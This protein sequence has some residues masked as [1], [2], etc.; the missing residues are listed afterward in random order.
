M[1]PIFMSVSS[2]N[3]IMLLND[4]QYA[5]D[6]PDQ[7]VQASGQHHQSQVR[8]SLERSYCVLMLRKAYGSQFAR[9]EFASISPPAWLRMTFLSYTAS[10]ESDIRLWFWNGF[11]RSMQDARSYELESAVLY[12]FQQIVVP[13]SLLYKA[14][15]QSE[16]Q[17]FLSG[18]TPLNSIETFTTHKGVAIS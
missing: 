10:D 18:E 12:T 14:V 16:Y 6:Q 1:L 17:H 2:L 9:F 8:P 4:L 5:G 15:Q 3:Y 11:M 7:E 13:C